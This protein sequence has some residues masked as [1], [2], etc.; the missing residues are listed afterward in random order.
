MKLASR[1]P[2]LA[3]SGTAT[4]IEAIAAER[5][6]EV[7]RQ[8]LRVDAVLKETASGYVATINSE[9]PLVRQRFSLAHEI[10]HVELFGATGLAQALRHISGEVISRTNEARE[11]E[12]LCDAF[13]AELLMPLKEWRSVLFKDGLSLPLLKALSERYKVSFDAASNRVMETAVR[14]CAIVLW[15]CDWRGDAFKGGHAMRVWANIGLPVGSLGEYEIAPRSFRAIEGLRSGEG[16]TSIPSRIY[17][18]CGEEEVDY[19]GEWMMYRGNPTRLVSLMIAERAGF[20]LI[21]QGNRS[22][23][24]RAERR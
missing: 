10:G 12:H 2:T 19:Y 11:V 23:K 1:L 14:K 18:R 6:I 21:R 4:P 5:H 20:A 3:K 7:Q 17:L 8:P 16:V 13:A 9:S 15:E 22:V 24:E